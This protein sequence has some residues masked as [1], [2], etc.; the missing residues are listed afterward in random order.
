MQNDYT[1]GNTQSNEWYFKISYIIL[2]MH[3]CKN[4]RNMLKNI[5]IPYHQHRSLKRTPERTGEHNVTSYSDWWSTC[6]YLTERIQQRSMMWK[7]RLKKE[8]RKETE[9]GMHTVYVKAQ[10]WNIHT[11]KSAGKK[12]LKNL[13]CQHRNQWHFTTFIWRTVLL[14]CNYISQ[15]YFLLYFWSI[16]AAFVNTR[17][18]FQ[19]Y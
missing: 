15:H 13:L 11:K 1:H 18:F 9:E 7:L 16:N 12:R 6:E 17:Y 14:N 10:V 4:L 3:A 8:W 2:R 19:K 5:T